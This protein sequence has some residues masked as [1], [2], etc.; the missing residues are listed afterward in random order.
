MGDELDS[1]INKRWIKLPPNSE[2]YPRIRLNQ[3]N[4]STLTCGSRQS[5]F[6]RHSNGKCGPECRS[7]DR[8]RVRCLAKVRRHPPPGWFWILQ[9]EGPCRKLDKYFQ[10]AP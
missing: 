8:K 3:K 10:Q 1:D 5:G 6:R 9:C 4:G 2:R 7:A